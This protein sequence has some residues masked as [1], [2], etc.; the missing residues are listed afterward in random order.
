MPNLCGTRAAACSIM[1]RA[2]IAALVAAAIESDAGVDR[3]MVRNSRSHDRLT[4]RISRAHQLL[5]LCPTHCIR[6]L[7]TVAAVLKLLVLARSHL[8]GDVVVLWAE[9]VLDELKAVWVY[10]GDGA[11]LT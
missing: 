1:W 9:C 4:L 8:V 2:S 7:P 3:D 6:R 10:A 11:S 5:T